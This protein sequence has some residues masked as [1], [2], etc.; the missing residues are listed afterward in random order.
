MYGLPVAGL[1]AQELLKKR[2]NKEGYY[3]SKM[4]HGLWH[5]KCCPIK[6]SLVIDDFGVKYV[7][8]EHAEHLMSIIR[9]HYQL[10]EDWEGK[11]YI[12]LKLGCD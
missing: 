2:L 3:Q 1:I 6:C 11:L 9:Q 10:I 8:K 7:V 12:G 5:H 4:V